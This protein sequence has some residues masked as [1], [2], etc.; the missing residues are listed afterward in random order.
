[1]F[2]ILGKIGATIKKIQKWVRPLT[3]GKKDGKYIERNNSFCKSKMNEMRQE[4]KEKVG[5]RESE[6]LDSNHLVQLLIFYL[7]Q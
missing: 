7:N 2:R 1:M 4:L 5:H 6:I 3:I